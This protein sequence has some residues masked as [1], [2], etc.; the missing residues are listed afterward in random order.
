[1]RKKSKQS[2]S[3]SQCQPSNE[4]IIISE[5]PEDVT[6]ERQ[7]ED[8]LTIAL[9]KSTQTCVKTPLD[10]IINFL[11]YRRVSTS[12]RRFHIILSQTIFPSATEAL[13]CPHWKKAM[14]EEMQ[15]LSKKQTWDAIKL[16]KGKKTVKCRWVFAI[17][18][19]SDG[20]LERYKARLLDKGYPHTYR[21]D[22][23][24]TFYPEAQ[25]NIIQIFY[26]FFNLREKG[27]PKRCPPPPIYYSNINFTS[28]C[29]S[30][31]KQFT[32]SEFRI[33]FISVT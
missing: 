25:M 16:Q 18:Y 23:K 4:G 8:Y 2:T 29:T 20:S 6:T 24:E 26:F 28:R 30:K 15:A 19:K 32:S 21:I 14:D 3:I 1:M 9:R 13:K 31:K 7:G 33:E 27:T 11:N 22:N 5:G 12:Y 17:K 10:A